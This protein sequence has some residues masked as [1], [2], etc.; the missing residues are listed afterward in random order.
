M[1]FARNKG[2]TEQIPTKISSYNVPVCYELEIKFSLFLGSLNLEFSLGYFKSL[3]DDFVVY[4]FD[5]LFH[6]G[7]QSCL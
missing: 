3:P 7:N 1:R 5:V 4:S 2:S 6:N